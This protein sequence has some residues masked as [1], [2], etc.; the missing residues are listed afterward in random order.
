ML[1][2]FT[3]MEVN[4]EGRLDIGQIKS[5]ASSHAPR[6]LS[7]PPTIPEWISEQFCWLVCGFSARFALLPFAF[8][9]MRGGCIAST[10]WCLMPR[11]ASQRGDY[12][13]TNWVHF[14]QCIWRGTHARTYTHASAHAH[15]PNPTHAPTDTPHACDHAR[16]GEAEFW[17]VLHDKEGS[18]DRRDPGE[19]GRVCH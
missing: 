5:A 6:S 2:A 4:P 10:G 19:G 8:K 9:S 1:Q 16:K 7:H 13:E 14:S 18:G 12:G 17:N 3:S 15:T 11:S